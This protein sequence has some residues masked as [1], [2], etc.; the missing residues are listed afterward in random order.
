MTMQATQVALGAS[1][2]IGKNSS[3]H[4]KAHQHFGRFEGSLAKAW[5]ETQ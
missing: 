4:P 1:Q 5:P 3:K 2:Q